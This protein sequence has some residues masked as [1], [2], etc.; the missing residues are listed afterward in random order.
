MGK[1]FCAEEKA[2]FSERIE[3]EGTGKEKD[4][5]GRRVRFGMCCSLEIHGFLR[6]ERDHFTS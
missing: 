1:G 5:V 6:P 3:G 2:D 4:E